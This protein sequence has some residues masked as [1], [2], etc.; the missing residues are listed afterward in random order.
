MDQQTLA[1]QKVVDYY[2]SNKKNP[3]DFIDLKDT[4]ILWWI[5]Q[6]EEKWKRF[7]GINIPEISYYEVTR[8]NNKI[9]VDVFTRYVR[10]TTEINN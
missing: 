8:Y 2:N 1:K 6:G 10:I 5:F 9:S 3:E 7:I 4:H